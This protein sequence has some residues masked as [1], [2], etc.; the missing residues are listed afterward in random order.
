MESHLFAR[1]PW[2]PFHPS[3]QW[4]T[5]PHRNPLLG[6]VITLRRRNKSTLPYSTL[7]SSSRLELP[8]PA[9]NRSLNLLTSLSPQCPQYLLKPR[10]TWCHSNSPQQPQPQPLATANTLFLKTIKPVPSFH[11]ENFS[12]CHSY[13]CTSFKPLLLFL[14]WTNSTCSND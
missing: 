7:C 4:Q 2:G 1:A 13:F 8:F 9:E 5:P 3:D 14:P 10:A 6:L 12:W 11:S